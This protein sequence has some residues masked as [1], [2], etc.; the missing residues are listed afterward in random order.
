VTASPPAPFAARL[1]PFRTECAHVAAT[2]LHVGAARELALDGEQRA[3]VLADLAANTHPDVL[4][5]A[6]E[7][8]YEALQ[9]VSLPRFLVYASTNLN[10]PK[11]AFWAIAGVFFVLAGIAIL[12]VLVTVVPVPPQRNRCY[13]LLVVA[14]AICATM[15]FTAIARGFCIK[16]G[17]RG[18]RQLRTWE[19]DVAPVPVSD[20]DRWWNNFFTEPRVLGKSVVDRRLADAEEARSTASTVFQEEVRVGSG[21]GSG[22]PRRSSVEGG[23]GTV[24]ARAR[25]DAE[26][27]REALADEVA[28]IAPFAAMLPPNSGKQATTIASAS[29]LDDHSTSETKASE[30]SGGDA[31]PVRSPPTFGPEMVVLDPR[32]RAFHASIIREVHISGIV[33]GVVCL[34]SSCACNMRCDAHSPFYFP[35]V[36]CTGDDGGRVCSSKCCLIRALIYFLTLLISFSHSL[37]SFPQ[38]HS[39]FTPS[40][41]ILVIVDDLVFVLCF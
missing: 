12:V 32:M 35:R 27:C 9:T 28:T 3:L 29:T 23:G 39:F 37:L 20:K 11:Q 16:V 14:A 24:E 25:R 19:L 36:L 13:R 6:Y 4:L 8:A 10:L 33:A 1:Q 41:L 18:H 2:F 22:G 21:D 17:K 26:R 5:P 40:F 31:G 34:L 30:G 15:T 7:C 38:K